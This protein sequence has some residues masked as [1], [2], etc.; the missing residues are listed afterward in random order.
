VSS[1]LPVDP[2]S[3]EFRRNIRPGPDRFKNAAQKNL[4]GATAALPTN[5]PLEREPTLER[6]L[7]PAISGENVQKFLFSPTENA[8][9]PPATLLTIAGRL[10]R[11]KQCWRAASLE[12]A[13]TTDV[14]S[15]T[16]A[17]STVWTVADSIAPGREYSGS[18]YKPCWRWVLVQA[19]P[20][21]KHRRSS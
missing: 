21:R 9:V 18:S 1:Q 14:R 6:R 7:E 17:V 20:L 2:S 12:R 15:P 11:I 13:E 19:L 16:K 5:Y 3:G 8:G 10:P 4:V